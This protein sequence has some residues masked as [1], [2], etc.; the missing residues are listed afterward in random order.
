ML[1]KL[2]QIYLGNKIVPSITK[3]TQTN[4]QKTKMNPPPPHNHIK[5]GFEGAK[6]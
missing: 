4:K 5:K 1:L 2:D 6:C 3:K